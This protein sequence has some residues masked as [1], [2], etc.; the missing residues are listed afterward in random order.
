MLAGKESQ[1]ICPFPL[2]FL[3]G[4]KSKLKKEYQTLI[5]KITIF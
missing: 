1:A 4:K 3:G 2:G 5:P